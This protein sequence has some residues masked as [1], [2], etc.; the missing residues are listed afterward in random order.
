M[1]KLLII[2]P[3]LLLT[4]CGPKI[5]LVPQAYMPTPP[6]LLMRDAKELNTIKKEEQPPAEEAKDE[7]V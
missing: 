6:E 7:R 3:L 2:A 4:A 1:K 5:K